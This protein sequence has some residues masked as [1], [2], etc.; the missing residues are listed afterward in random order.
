[1]IIQDSSSKSKTRRKSRFSST[2]SNLPAHNRSYP[3]LDIAICVVFLFAAVLVRRVQRGEHALTWFLHRLDEDQTQ[4]KYTFTIQILPRH[5]SPVPTSQDTG[6]RDSSCSLTWAEGLGLRY[7]VQTVRL[8]VMTRT[9]L[10]F[11]AISTSFSCQ[12]RSTLMACP[13]PSPLALGWICENPVDWGES[14]RIEVAVCWEVC[15]MPLYLR[16]EV[17]EADESAI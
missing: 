14:E 7:V 8:S 13:P 9:M 17:R 5:G 12:L 10:P 6:L 11:P 16:I 1:M 3:V 2:R 15:D 4:K